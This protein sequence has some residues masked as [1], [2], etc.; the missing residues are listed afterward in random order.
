MGDGFALC[1]RCILGSNTYC[2]VNHVCVVGYR[3]SEEYAYSIA[4]Q[5][6]LILLLNSE[7]FFSCVQIR[8]SMFVACCVPLADRRFVWL[9][10]TQTSDISCCGKSIFSG[11]LLRFRSVTA[12]QLS[13]RFFSFFCAF[14]GR[15][16]LCNSGFPV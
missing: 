15:F 13:V 3:T 14:L 1:F 9:C 8:V 2:Q 6:V 7:P 4:G 10:A 12:S 5:T 16:R 11:R